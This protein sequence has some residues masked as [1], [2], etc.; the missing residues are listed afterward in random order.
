[1]A[2]LDGMILY[3]YQQL[4]QVCSRS[5]L[6]QRRLFRIVSYQSWRF[7]PQRMLRHQEKELRGCSSERQA[8]CPCSHES[9]KRDQGNLIHESLEIESSKEADLDRH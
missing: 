9:L 2:C 1:M 4:S 7:L 3:L 6:Y 5:I 8:P